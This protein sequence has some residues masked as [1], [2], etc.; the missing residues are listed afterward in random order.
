MTLYVMISAA[1]PATAV[2]TLIVDAQSRG[3]AVCLLA[4]PNAYRWLDVESLE[5]LTGF[6]VR[7]QHKLPGQLDMLPKADAVIVAPLS[8]N[9]LSKWALG[10]CDNLVL[11]V[12]IELTGL[13]L[14]I[15]ALPYFNRAQA[16]HPSV[17]DSIATLRRSGVNVLHREPHESGHGGRFPWEWTLKALEGDE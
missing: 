15:V 10:I 13:G 3:H 16:A 14:P 2:D 6:P 9:T 1:G 17:E 8:L 5:A 11:S 4:T 12:V 7:H